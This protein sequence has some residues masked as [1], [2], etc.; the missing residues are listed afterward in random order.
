MS[1]RDGG[2]TLLE[3]VVALSLSALVLA[4]AVMAL[5]GTERMYAAAAA[6]SRQLQGEWVLY[7]ALSDD[8]HEARSYRFVGST[9]W[10]EREDGVAD[11]FR[12]SAGSGFIVLETG[13]YGSTVLAADVT[14]L[15]YA[16]LP[17]GGL[18]VTMTQTEGGRAIASEFWLAFALGAAG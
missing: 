15:G 4:A 16:V 1:A 7:R 9:L 2:F 8:L 11:V 13:G 5:A 14:S 3:A 10:V 18:A 17:A 6:R 12:L